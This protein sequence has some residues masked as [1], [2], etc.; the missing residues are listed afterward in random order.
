MLRKLF[1]T[2]AL[3]GAV[4]TTLC[5]LAADGRA[6]DA[7]PAQL[8][9][10]PFYLVNDMEEGPLKDALKACAAGPFQRTNF[11]ISHRGATLQFPEHTREGYVAGASMGAGI[12]ECDVTFTKDRQLVCRH[13]QC[14]LHT[15]TD[16]LSKP[17]LAA[18]CT[19]PFSPA[20]AAA[21]KKAEA[22]CCTS[23]VTLAEFRQLRGKMDGANTAATTVADYMKGTPAWRTDLYGSTGTLMTLKESIALFKEFGTKFTPELKAP[24]VKMPFDGDYTDDAYAQQMIDEF[25]Q[26]GID[27]AMVFPQSFQLRDILYWIKNEPA[28]GKQG[29]FLDERDETVKGFDTN[30]PETWQ[31]SM[32]ELVAQGVKIIAPSM[33]MLVTLDA[34]KTIVPSAYAKAAKEAGLGIITWSLERS[35]TLTDGGGYY[36]SS[37]KDA[38]HRSGDTYKLL[39]VLAKQVGVMGVFSD[40]PATVTYYANCMGL[41]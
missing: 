14:D 39:D 17:E 21:G 30:K 36:Y 37:V 7:P 16:I 2:G 8:G 29:V 40:W 9:P 1:A 26:A 24:S 10:R 28:F 22:S 31:P 12:M 34:N 11:S 23:D 20:D 25:K 32:Q 6:Q 33:H 35:G 3:L 18:K 15:S 27:P 4:L 13:S 5:G 38:I 41:K 19:K